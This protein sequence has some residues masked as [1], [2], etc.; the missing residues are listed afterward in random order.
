MPNGNGRQGPLIIFIR[1]LNDI[2][3]AQHI[4]KSPQIYSKSRVDLAAPPQKKKK[5]NQIV[6]IRF[7]YNYGSV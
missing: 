7:S 2:P 5:K 1:L 4:K 3:N 6:Q